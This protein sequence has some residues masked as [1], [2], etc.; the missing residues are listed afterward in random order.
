M[1]DYSPEDRDR[2]R[3][4]E[5][6]VARLQRD[7]SQFF[8]RYQPQMQHNRIVRMARTIADE[9]ADPTYPI[10]GIDGGNTFPIVFLSAGFTNEAGKNNLEAV[11]H[12][13]TPQGFVRILS[14]S[15]LP[16]S[17]TLQV[18]QDRGTDADFKGEWFSSFA[19]RIRL[20]VT[21]QAIAEDANGNVKEW[22][23]GNWDERESDSTWLCRNWCGYDLEPNT[24]VFFEQ[25]GSVAYIIN[26]ACSASGSGMGSG[27]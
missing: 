12:D 15:W 20:G 19:D 2:I 4:L 5:R 16:Q 10:Q 9:Q 6:E 8:S 3:Q 21:L 13:T 17:S 26:A 23:T 27:A 24:R 18:W 22:D 25:I 7:Q 14:G 11:A 1:P